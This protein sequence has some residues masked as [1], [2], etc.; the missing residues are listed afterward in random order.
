MEILLKLYELFKRKEWIFQNDFWPE[1][2]LP[3][4]LNDWEKSCYV[5]YFVSIDYQTK[6]KRLVEKMK[7]AVGKNKNIINP[8]YLKDLSLEEIA[9]IIK[10][11]G[12]RFPTVDNKVWKHNSIILIEKF[13]GDPR[14]IGDNVTIQELKERMKDFMKYKSYGKLFWL[15]TSFMI[16]FGFWKIKDIENFLVPVDIWVYRFA[17]KF[18]LTNR[19]R[20][21][22]KVQEEVGRKLTNICLDLGIPFT[23]INHVIWRFMI[24]I[25]GKNKCKEC[26]LKDTCYVNQF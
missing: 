10:E 25:C 20:Y 7:N 2:Y 5:F 23:K 8:F 11:C 26:L 14:K 18:G 12:G 3:E 4:N 15:L 21:D 24:E 22:K 19:E 9:K 13:Q 6:G 17:R 1:D 16:D